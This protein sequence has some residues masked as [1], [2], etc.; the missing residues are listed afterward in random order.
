MTRYFG[1]HTLEGEWHSLLPRYVLLADRVEGKRVLD[2][3]CGTGIG[4]S[5]L[6]E[7]GALQVNA[8]DHR[9]AVLELARVKHAKE[10]LNFH[11]MFWEELDFPADTFDIVLCL[12]PTSPVTDPSLLQEIKRVLKAHGEYVCAIEHRNIE[13]V[14]SL[15]PRYGYNNSGEEVSL[16]RSDERVPQLGQLNKFFDTITAIT[17]RPHYSYV[18]DHADDET[19]E[20]QG[21]R[22]TGSDE[23]GIWVGIG[24]GNAPRE[25]TDQRPGRWVEA[26]N[27]LCTGDGDPA[28]VNLLFCGDA[29]MHPPSLREVEMPYL[30]LV[31]H[32][33]KLISDLQIRQHPTQDPPPFGDVIESRDHDPLTMEFSDR[34]RT[35]EFFVLDSH[36]D[37]RFFTAPSPQRRESADDLGQIR[38]QIEQMLGLYQQM[39]DEMEDLVQSTRE[40]LGERDRYIEELVDTVHRWQHHFARETDEEMGDE[41]YFESEPTRVFS[42]NEAT[43][44]I[45]KEDLATATGTTSSRDEIID[46]SED[47]F[48]DASSGDPDESSL[49][50]ASESNAEDSLDSDQAADESESVTEKEQD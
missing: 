50:E 16:N 18:F 13:G 23:S 12:D 15:L 2:I 5:L 30:S 3:G 29:H 17:Q 43:R 24:P 37:H 34:E 31:G 36:K 39:R 32:L 27:R 19:V 35:N 38:R 9:P 4:A 45:N 44:R 33:H 1:L 47:N 11:V 20:S 49:V 10:G 42:R 6:L 14:E 7:M 28:S 26:D 48:Y 40:E 8:I 22:R 41:P 25:Q 21:I 46:E